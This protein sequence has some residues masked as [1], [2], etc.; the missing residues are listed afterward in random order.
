[1]T[2]LYLIR[3]GQNEYVAKGKLA[4]RLPGVHLDEV[5]RRQAAALAEQLKG[6][7]FQ[8]IYA[9]PLERTMETAAP[10][11]AMQGKKVHPLEGLLEIDYGKWQGAS[12]KLLHHRKLW[13][14]IQHQPS[15]VQ[16]PEG[17]SF[18]QAQARVVATL[19]T[20]RRR[21]HSKKARVACV[22]HSDPIKLAIA[23]YLGLPHDLFHRLTI[24]PASVSVFAIGDA[25]TRLLMLNDSRATRAGGAG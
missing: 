12:L 23:H 21:H 24:E 22:F 17:E 5:G 2:I 7:R 13:A 25:F 10:L 20:I 3:H 4:G 16:F 15:L 11:A 9:S 19:E 8:A 14:V 6:V 1:M 18:P